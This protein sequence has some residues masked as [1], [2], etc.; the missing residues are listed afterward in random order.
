MLKFLDQ[1]IKSPQTIGAIC[2]S[3]RALAEVMVE[4]INFNQIRTLVEIGPGT[5]AITDAIVDHLGSHTRYLG[6]ELN[7]TFHHM[8]CMQYKKLEFVLGDAK[9]T[10]FILERMGLP[11]ADAIV[12]SL[13]W[14]AFKIRQQ[15]RLL[16]AIYR[17]LKPGGYFT[18]FAYL[19]GMALP[20]AWMLRYLLRTRFSHVEKSRT[21]WNNVPP[22]FA[23]I[24][25][26]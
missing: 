4:P 21:V 15:L 17:S 10:P 16:N 1:S 18:T 6:I 3:S 9:D 19:Q 7:Q 12:C 11:A 14:A 22:A 23:Y 8:L 5:G 25:Y 24:C 26:K 2:P 13:P 20:S